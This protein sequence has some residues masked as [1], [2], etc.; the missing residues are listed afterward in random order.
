MV[1]YGN[2]N[3]GGNLSDSI[4]NLNKKIDLSLMIELCS[5]ICRG[6]VYLHSKLVIHRDLKPGN[7]LVTFS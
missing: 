7:I 1:I 4:H 6:M 5:S 3:L 2:D